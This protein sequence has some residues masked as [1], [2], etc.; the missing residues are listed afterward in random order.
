M[1]TSESGNKKEGSNKK[2]ERVNLSVR[3]SLKLSDPDLLADICASVANG[4]S[5]LDL[6]AVW[7][8]RYSDVVHWIH[9]E[10]ADPRRKRCYEDALRA[11]SEYMVQSVLDELKRIGTVD[12]RRAYDKAGCLLPVHEIPEDVARVI[13]GIE[14]KEL[15]ERVDD[16]EGGTK[17]EKV[18]EMV[19]VKF[20]DKIKALELL[21]KNMALWID[22]TQHELKGATLEELVAGSRRKEEQPAV[23]TVEITAQPSAPAVL[24]KLSQALEADADKVGDLPV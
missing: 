20:L 1:T 15:W 5:L 22:R 24:D 9:D 3:T 11:R 6:C 4:G 17:M 21:G 14:A 13:V 2:E 10:I 8:V 12:I 16:G 7:Q 19:K 18:G 23:K